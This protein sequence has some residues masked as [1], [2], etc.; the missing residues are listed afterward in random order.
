MAPV[1][2]SAVQAVGRCKSRGLSRK[3]QETKWAVAVAYICS[4]LFFPQLRHFK[5][6][7]V[8]LCQAVNTPTC[9]V[10]LKL[11]SHHQGKTPH[12]CSKLQYKRVCI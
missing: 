11:V 10:W 3:V 8:L 7:W 2:A 5:S 1:G 12:D 9:S 4:K 6:I